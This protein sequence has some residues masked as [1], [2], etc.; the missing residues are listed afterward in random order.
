MYDVF[1]ERM[2]LHGGTNRKRLLNQQKAYYRRSVMDS[3]SCKQVKLNGM[4][5]YLIVDSHNHSYQKLIKS[6]PDEKFVTGDYVEWAN[7]T[8]LVLEAD[9]DDELYTDGLMQ[10]CTWHL[11]WQLAD[12]RI[13]RYWGVDFNATQ[14]NS[15][16]TMMNDRKYVYGSSQHKV[17]LPYDENTIMMRTPLRVFLSRNM[18]EPIVFK[19]AQNDSTTFN[20]GTGIVDVM[21]VEDKFNPKTDK[22]VTLENGE[23]VWIADYD[24]P[25][26]AKPSESPIRSEISGGSKLYVGQPMEFEVSFKNEFNEEI[27]VDDFNWNL[28]FVK[29]SLD[30]QIQNKTIVLFTED[31]DLINEEIVLQMYVEGLFSSELVI[32]VSGFY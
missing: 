31:E 22:L 13:V 12:G 30:V 9:Y 21:F 18:K 3:L 24:A 5:S 32:T 29:D 4:E 10:Q 8:W 23:K 6:L 27:E 7:A 25:V 2:E 17:F 11:T 19:V 1:Q 15:G 26:L 28:A 20:Y 16:E 14:Y